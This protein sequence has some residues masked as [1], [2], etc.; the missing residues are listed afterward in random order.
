MEGFVSEIQ[1]ALD[2]NK[3]RLDFWRGKER[4]DGF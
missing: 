2:R 1:K 4:E 3:K